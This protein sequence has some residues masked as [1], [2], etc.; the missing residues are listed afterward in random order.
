[1]TLDEWYEKFPGY[2]NYEPRYFYWLVSKCVTAEEA[3]DVF[4]YA[5]RCGADNS[6]LAGMVSRMVE[7]ERL[8]R[9]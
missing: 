3:M 5:C 7:D 8:S 9:V 1:M 6:V 2:K 4:L